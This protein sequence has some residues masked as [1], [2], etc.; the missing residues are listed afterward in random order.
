MA[1]QLGPA[2]TLNESKTEDKTGTQ[3]GQTQSLANFLT[4][5]FGN[6][7][8]T[9][10]P[11]AGA[12][13]QGYNTLWNAAA[14]AFQANQSTPAYGGN[15]VA[16][17]PE[18]FG[19]GVNLLDQA[20]ERAKGLQG[21]DQGAIDLLKNTVGGQYLSPDSNP[22]LRGA[23]D[24]AV[25]RVREQLTNQVLPGLADQSIAQG[26]YG[27]ARQD[28]AQGAAVQ[29]FDRAALE[30]TN[31]LYGGNYQFERGN[32]LASA[33]ALQQALQQSVNFAQQPAQIRLNQ[34][35]LIRG[36]NQL[37]LDNELAKYN[38]NQAAPWQG[39][40]QFAGALGAGNFGTST[41]SSSSG[42]SG[43]NN[44]TNLQNLINTLQG[45]TNT[46]KDNPNYES[47][48]LQL[49]KSGLG[50]ASGV[51]GIGGAQGFGLWGK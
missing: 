44:T 43:Q 3:S 4:N 10:A 16:T 23:A 22:F 9:N 30:A 8:T 13:G 19:W 11:L 35:E 6:Q 45:T 51:A 21:Q 36:A 34:A 49:L 39:L 28:L 20:V 27:G 38:Y 47:P 37:A 2:K 26:A 15:F 48:F 7:T 1:G 31:A 5:A 12:Q 17:A 40:S 18:Q 33:P 50:V 32:Q 14:N 24:A 29:D 42:T 41:T 46:Q 25:G